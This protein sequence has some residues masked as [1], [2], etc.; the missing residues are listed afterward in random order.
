MGHLTRRQ[1]RKGLKPKK[2]LASVP[3]PFH[4]SY[5]GFYRRKL[6]NIYS[7]FSYNTKARMVKP[8]LWAFKQYNITED[9]RAIYY[10]QVE[11]LFRNPNLIPR[12][13]LTNEEWLE[14][15]RYF[16]D[17]STQIDPH[18][19]VAKLLK[20]FQE[21]F[22]KID[23]YAAKFQVALY[24]LCAISGSTVLLSF[25]NIIEG[26]LFFLSVIITIALLILTGYIR[27][28]QQDTD[29]FHMINAKL[30][31]SRRELFHLNRNSRGDK[32]LLVMATIWNCSLT[33]YRTISRLILML[34][35]KMI[36]PTFYNKILGSLKTIIP[37]NLEKIEKLLK[38]K[39]YKKLRKLLYDEFRKNMKTT[40]PLQI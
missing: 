29:I 36:R 40:E 16:G 23:E 17:K 33:D 2:S 21:S 3:A 24:I 39:N 32:K 13:F 18:K 38:D 25:F 4:P 34:L 1:R 7:T 10:A 8:V 35:L 27:L 28:L 12:T 22:K 26:K 31:I 37:K 19:N 14:R 6:K 9:S 30:K 11:E 15:A 5:L 20:Y